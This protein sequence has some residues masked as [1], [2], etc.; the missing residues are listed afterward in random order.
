MNSPTAAAP[1][2]R[3][4]AWLVLVLVSGLV[5]VAARLVGLPS[6]EI[7]A[8][9]VGGIVLALS[10]RGPR[11][12]PH[13]ANVAAQAVIGVV[14]GSMVTSEELRALSDDWF[15]V[16]VVTVL[17]LMISFGSGFLLSLHRDVDRITGVLSMAAGGASGL[18]AIAEELGGDP[19]VVGMLQYARVL[20]ITASTP[21]VAAY[22]FGAATAPP[23]ASGADP[24]WGAPVGV[25]CVVVGLV[26]ARLARI[27]AGHLLGPMVVTAAVSIQGS[28]PTPTLPEVLVATAF[29]LVGWTATLGFT[30]SAIATVGRILP[31]ALALVVLLI[32]ASAAGGW[33]LARLVGLPALDGYLAT[34][35]GGMFA[36]LAIAAGSGS[37]VTFITGVQTVRLFLMLAL[38]PLLTGWLRRRAG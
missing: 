14:L 21:M 18:V 12:L 27:P 30:R 15:G 29:V 31:A 20:L 9:M 34:T 38:T 16:L 11:G 35:P 4:V 25:G 1:W 33:W 24:A 3:R 26:L 28:L 17:T 19:R 37:N 7:L 23:A 13:P 8:G 6:P 5:L 2:T 36:M 32:L 10:G 22:V